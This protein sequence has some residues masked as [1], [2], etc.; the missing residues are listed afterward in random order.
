MRQ[1]LDQLTQQASTGLVATTYAGLGDG[2]PVALDLSPQIAGLQTFQNN[3]DA[4][5]GPMGVTQATMTQIQQIAAKLL[6]K[7]SQSERPQRLRGGQHRRPRRATRCNRWPGCSM[8]R[9][10]NVFVFAGADTAN[11]P[12]P[13]PSGILSSGFFTQIASAVGNLGSA[14]ASATAAATLGIAG[15]NA[16]GTSPFSAYL[17]Q[18]ATTLQAQIPVVQTGPGQT[19]QIGLLASANTAVT[20]PAGSTTGSYMR[21]LMRSLA[22]LGSLSS[23]QINLPGFAGLVQDTGTSLQGAITAMAGDVGVLGNRQAALTATQT[24]LAATQTALTTQLGVGAGRGHGEDAVGPDADADPASGVV[25]GDRRA[26][27]PVARKT[28]SGRGMR[29]HRM[30]TPVPQNEVLPAKSGVIRNFVGER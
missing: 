3:I 8:P 26:E 12:V 5:T 4:A 16:A 6:R 21:D 25:P 30:L 22:T 13:N 9:T 23:S 19:T 14:G 10:G 20:S 2:A 27:Q 1:R 28:S 7:N 29:L 18:P 24:Q 17:S 15:S 11:P